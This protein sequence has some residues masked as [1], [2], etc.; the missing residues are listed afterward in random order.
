MG[1]LR[2]GAVI[3][4][5]HRLLITLD[6]KYGSRARLQCAASLLHCKIWKCFD[7]IL[8]IYSLWNTTENCK[9]AASENCTFKKATEN[10]SEFSQIEYE[11]T[12]LTPFQTTGKGL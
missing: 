3:G 8:L 2:V 7:E 6:G 1:V 12:V 10:R 5:H 9:L 4:T 11:N